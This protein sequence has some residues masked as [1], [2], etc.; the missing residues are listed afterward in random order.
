MTQEDA[1]AVTVTMSKY[2]AFFVNLMMTEE[3]GLQVPDDKEPTLLRAFVMFA[4]FA[5]FGMLP[6]VGYVL[7]AFVVQETAQP[8]SQAH[9]MLAACVITSVTLV[10]LG[11][12]K[13][14]F[15][16]RRYVRSALETLVLGGVCASLSYNVG[17][18]VA[19]IDW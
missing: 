19:S 10:A 11:A 16:H 15:A 1:Q 4:A 18:A 3:L 12:F 2:P 17:L 5:L 8:P 6:I 13:A 7:T 9:M 14:H